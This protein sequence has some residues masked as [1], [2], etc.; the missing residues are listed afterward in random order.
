MSNIYQ[1]AKSWPF[2]EARNLLKKL[3]GK[4][5]K[6]GFVLF[7]TG[8]GPSGLP[9]IGTFGEVA[10]TSMVRAAFNKLAPEI[11]TKLICFSDDMDGLR[12]VPSNLPN[13]QM[14][15][16]NLGK[17]LTQIPDPFEKEESFG[18]YMNNKLCEFLDQF[19]FAYEFVSSTNE[20]K[21]GKFNKALENLCKNYD[22]IK[23]LV[24]NTLGE[25]RRAHYSPL[26]PIC[27]AS[28]KVL[29]QGV[30]E[31]DAEKF[32]IRFEDAAGKQHEIYV[33]DGN[34]KL[35]WKADFGM[36]WHALDVDYEMYGKD[37]IPSAELANKISKILGKKAPYNFHY[38]LFLDETGQKISKSKGNGLTIDEWL[39]YAPEKSLE[40]YMF[41]KPKTAKRLY[42]DVIPKAV[43]EYFTHLSKYSQLEEAQQIDNVISHIH[44]DGIQGKLK[45]SDSISFALLLN[46]AAA[47]NPESKDILWGFISK[48]DDKLTASNAPVLDELAGYA[49]R[50]YDDFIKQH[51]NFRAAT[52]KERD[53]ILSLAKQLE[54][55]S[56]AADAAEIQTLIYDIGKEYEFELRLWFQ[57]LY[58][59]LLGQSQGPRMGSFIKLFG[60]KEMLSLIN[61]KLSSKA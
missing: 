13:Q 23:N 7:E 32:T 47:C 57:A 45:E 19:G 56:D 34:C 27:P 26:M 41:L 48:Y 46:L 35:Q 60:V 52:A 3:N 12:K 43:D 18:L 49:V 55:L 40:Y 11:P 15:E 25:E 38:E 6:K 61:E 51:K 14:L 4:T 30:L 17:P 21:S 8:Y 31:V 10:R 54:N 42:F 36:R 44:P 22:I 50:Y 39:S 5:P 2:I 33:G 9:H 20:Y 1:N 37:I 24:A 58:E 28:G 29:E 16:E 53:A 59:I